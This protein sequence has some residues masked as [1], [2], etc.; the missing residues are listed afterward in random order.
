MNAGEALAVELLID[1]ATEGLDPGQQA[2]LSPLLERFPEL[3]DD[4]FELA[5]AA[6]ELAHTIPAQPLP[7]VLRQ[8]VAAQAAEHLAA[9]D[10][11]P[12][13]AGE[14]VPFPAVRA[15]SS[16]P[17]TDPAR[18]LGWL[19][20]AACLALAVWSWQRRPQAPAPAEARAELVAAAGELLQLEWTA[21][22]DPAAR[23]AGGDLVWSTAAQAGYMR[24][25]GLPVNDPS[26]E[27][28]QLWIFDAE[29]DEATPVD[30]GVFD[31]T[32]AGEVVVPI[33]A[34]LRI[35]RPT[36]FAVT[37]EKPGGVVV[38]SRERL[39]LLAKVG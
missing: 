25:R 10:R 6:V 36:L 16:G 21:T 30:G 24:F 17:A 28:Y 20:A 35:V 2:R 11:D 22:E 1:R 29:Q 9:Q 12:A 31:V 3:D 37:V 33:D 8:R 26:I 19:A 27:Q 23:D 15:A 14:V 13:T 34:K 7:A 38:S 4:S 5:A 39:P 32:A 18:W